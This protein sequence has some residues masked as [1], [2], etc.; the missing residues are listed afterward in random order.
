MQYG[1][2]LSAWIS[3][4]LP[5]FLAPVAEATPSRGVFPVTARFETN[6]PDPFERGVYEPLVQRWA[7]RF[8]RVRWLQQGRLTLYLVYIFVATVAALVWALVRPQLT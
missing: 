2:S 4:F 5:R 1:S 6:A 3:G 8:E 7:K